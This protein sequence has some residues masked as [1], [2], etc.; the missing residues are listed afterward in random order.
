MMKNL[1]FNNHGHGQVPTTK[2]MLKILGVLLTAPIS[3]PVIMLIE[4]I[5]RKKKEKK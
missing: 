1:L 3:I 2:E 5:K 4:K